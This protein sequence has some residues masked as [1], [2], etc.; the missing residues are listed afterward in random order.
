MT[1]IRQYAIQVKADNAISSKRIL[2]KGCLP[3]V[4]CAIPVTTLCKK[5]DEWQHDNYQLHLRHA[6]HKHVFFR[7]QQ[8]EPDVQLWPAAAIDRFCSWAAIHC[9]P[10]H[11]DSSRHCCSCDCYHTSPSANVQLY[12]TVFNNALPTA[13]RVGQSV[14]GGAGRA[15]EELHQP[16]HPGERL[17][18]AAS[19]ERRAGGS[20]ERPGGARP[21]GPAA[22]GARV[23]LR[24]CSAGGAGAAAGAPGDTARYHLADNINSQLNC[25]S[26][27]I[28]DI[29]E[30]LNAANAFSAQDKPLQQ[31]SK[32]LNTHMDAL[33]WIQ[34]NSDL[35]QQKLQ[36]LERSGQQQR[37]D[38]LLKR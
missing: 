35:L 24:G 34:H 20:A 6:A 7:G 13:G 36:D 5:Q 1:R 27:D 26:R 17:G 38:S 10:C 28:R 18:S 4:P 14:E 22:A 12:C 29:V 19:G 37:T 9:S 21:A 30:Q 32:V 2:F 3:L 15:G 8:D 33:M 11:S 31:I 23:G 16:G 25:V